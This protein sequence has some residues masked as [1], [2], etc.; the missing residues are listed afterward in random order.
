[1]DYIYKLTERVDSSNAGIVE[2][3]I[4]AAYESKGDLSI[5]AGELN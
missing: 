3:D 4:F 5:D 2:K 1:M